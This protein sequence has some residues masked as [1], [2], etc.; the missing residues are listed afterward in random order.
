MQQKYQAV[1]ISPALAQQATQE[2][3]TKDPLVT[4]VRERYGFSPNSRLSAGGAALA[5]FISFPLGAALPML[6]MWQSPLHWREGT[7]FLAVLIM[8]VFT[9]YAAASLNGANRQHAAVRNVLAG[10]FTMVV[11]FIIGSFFR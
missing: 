5:S 3:M 1:G 2:M 8:L 11:T 6:A 10:I 9:G 4:T 7:T